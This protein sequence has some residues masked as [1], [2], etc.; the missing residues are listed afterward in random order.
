[1]LSQDSLEEAT[2]QAGIDAPPRFLERTASTNTEAGLLAEAGAPE[3]TVVAAGHQTAGRGRLGRTWTSAPGRSL[4]MSIVLRPRLPPAEAPLIP[5][6]AAAEMVGACGAP[7]A[8]K[9]PN[10]LVAGGRKLGGILPEA[11]LR[12]GVLGHLVL[13]IGINVTMGEDDFPAELRASATSLALEGV[14]VEVDS[15][16]RRFLG[17][18]RQRY[19][20][21]EPGFPESVVRAYGPVC[22]TLGRRVR[23]STTDGATVEGTAVGLDATGGLVLETDRERRTVAFGEVAH[24]D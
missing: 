15:L 11:K 20:P 18:F 10:D 3:W 7:V 9:W 22:S 24:L 8:A 21:D 6:L 4:L 2:R 12:G 5:L 23:A 16:L 17:G 1:V 13:G 14:T 19:R